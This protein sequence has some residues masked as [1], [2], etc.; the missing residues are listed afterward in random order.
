VSPIDGTGCHGLEF[1]FPA[2][3]LPTFYTVADAAGIALVT[4]QTVRKWFKTKELTEYHAG[5]SFRVL[6]AELHEFL[7][8]G[9]VSVEPT[10]RR[11]EETAHIL[12]AEQR[13]R[14]AAALGISA[15]PSGAGGAQMTG[16]RAAL[17]CQ[18]VPTPQQPDGRSEDR[19]RGAIEQRARELA[20]LARPLTC[21]QFVLLK[22]VFSHTSRGG[23]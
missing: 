21:E 12:N 7:R 22:A 10:V 9:R 14:L 5:R 13:A 18:R 1:A 3:E 6:A 8:T 23:G 2:L 16:M 15:S 17:D 20:D 11:L 4:P 19:V